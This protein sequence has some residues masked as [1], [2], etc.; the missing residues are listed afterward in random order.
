ML[1][2][3]H[4][5]PHAQYGYT[6]FDE[7]QVYAGAGYAVVLGNPRGAAGLRRGP[8]PGDRHRLGTV[9]ADDLLALLDAALATEGTTPSGSASWAARTAGS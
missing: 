3:I 9:D 6:L 2:A 7:A 5:G 8:R 4:G 1:L